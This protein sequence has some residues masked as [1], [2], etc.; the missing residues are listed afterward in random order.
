[1]IKIKAF[2]P[3]LFIAFT[4]VTYAQETIIELPHIKPDSIIWSNPEKEYISKL[5]NAPV[6]TNVSTPSLIVYKPTVE[7]QNGI[8]VI[9]A[10]GGGLYTLS[11]NSEGRKV[12]EWLNSK[13]ITAFIL[14][15]RLVPTGK[16]GIQD[17]K[18][19]IKNDNEK[20]VRITKKLMPYSTAD[21][22]NAITY[23]REHSKMLGVHPNKIGF[24][25]FSAG[26]CVLFGVVNACNETNRP[27]FLVPVYP[28]TDVIDPEPNHLTPPT[29]FIAAANDK[30]ID[31]TTF[32]SIFN[33]WHKAGIKTGMHMYADGGHGFGTWLKGL[34]VSNW[35]D[36]FYEWVTSKNLLE[37]DFSPK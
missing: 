33:K 22:L 29:L 13:G 21:G 26:G 4:M 34:P 31:A 30:L 19:I 28:G 16:D 36:R 9:I 10:P 17:L 23:V 5:G 8:S 37:Q 7:K 2:L 24:M 11:I 14:K 32:T 35:L 25:G 3:Y 20:R 12:A 27:N 6:I 1:M 15:Y 18:E